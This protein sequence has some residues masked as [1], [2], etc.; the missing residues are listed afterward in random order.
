MT[1]AF[2][3]NSFAESAIKWAIVRVA[4]VCSN[5][6]LRF[7][8]AAASLLHGRRSFRRQPQRTT[9]DLANLSPNPGSGLAAGGAPGGRGAPPRRGGELVPLPNG[10]PRRLL[11]AERG[12]EQ[13]LVDLAVENRNP[14]LPALGKN[15]LA[16]Q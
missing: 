12:K 9:H 16:I 1:A 11:L 8:Q 4:V 2:P 5:V 3:P 10:R 14:V 7:G 6:Y 15:L 13:R